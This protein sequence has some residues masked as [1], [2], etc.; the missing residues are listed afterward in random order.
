MNSTKL[1][2]NQSLRKRVICLGLVLILINGW[3]LIQM[4]EFRYSGHP[5]TAS[6]FFN[7]I[8]LLLL[9]T[10][11]NLVV[12]R[13]IPKVALSQAELLTLYVMLSIASA[14]SGHDQLVGLPPTLGHPFWFAT[15]ENEWDVLFFSHIPLWLAVSDKNVLRGYYQGESSFYFSSH[16]RAW[17]GPLVWWSLFYLVV[18][19]IILCINSILRR[20]WIESEKLSYP[21]IQLPLAMTTGGNFWRN[22]LLWIGFAIAGF[23]DLVNG[24]HFLFPTIPELPVRQRDISYLFT[25]KPFNAIGWLPISFYPFAIGLCFFIP[26]DL[27]FSVWF[28]YLFSKTQR[29]IGGLTGWHKIAGFPYYDEQMFGAALVIFFF[30][31][32]GGKEHLK[33]VLK[34]ALLIGR[35]EVRDNEL[36]ESTPLGQSHDTNEPISY[37]NALLG[38]TGG[39]AFLVFFCLRAGMDIWILPLYFGIYFILWTTITRI[40]AQL[41]PPVHDFWSYTT[42]KTWGH[43]DMM[44]VPFFGTRSL[45]ANNL[46]MF[47]FFWGLFKGYRGG[48][49]PHQLE[50]FKLA[51][52]G[53]IDNRRLFWAILLASVVGIISCLWVLMYFSYQVGAPGVHYYGGVYFNKYLPR[54]LSHPQTTDYTTIVAMGA[55][56]LFATFLVVMQRGFLKWPFH[57]VG[58]VLSGSWTMNLVWF[59]FLI[60]WFLKFIILKQGGFQ[61]Y[62]SA[63]PFFFGLILGEF[64]IG[65]VWTI[66]GV[67]FDQPSYAFWY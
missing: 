51:E 11:F 63:R 39:M 14:I 20:Q 5:T 57:P 22:R 44:L 3:W 53:H 9:L 24:A 40:R 52:Q 1:V 15:P 60:G 13:F 26:L 4:E 12:T 43:P 21:V 47:S 64:T 25:E 48:P 50:G 28:F 17:F 19:L 31:I 8:F 45:G 6:L 41:G 55:G 56:G 36:V 7:V 58:Y 42:G 32:W 46:T 61:A 37:R 65:T 67:L 62:R 59:V 2:K 27:T 23:I 29:I 18:L 35:P 30:A 66:V 33:N 54:W 34:T 16:L 10:L 38:I 49:A